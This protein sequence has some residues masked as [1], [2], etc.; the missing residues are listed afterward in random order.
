VL[1]KLIYGFFVTLCLFSPLSYGQN[2]SYEGKKSVT[3]GKDYQLLLSLKEQ[4]PL[5]YAQRYAGI[6]DALQESLS[7]YRSSKNLLRKEKEILE[8]ALDNF[9]K[10][11]FNWRTSVERKLAF[12]LYGPDKRAF[13]TRLLAEFKKHYAPLKKREEQLRIFHSILSGVKVPTFEGL[14]FEE[15]FLKPKYAQEYRQRKIA[16]YETLLKEAMDLPPK[17]PDKKELTLLYRKKID[18][19]R[20]R[21]LPTHKG[22]L[23]VLPMD[24]L[25]GITAL[26]SMGYT[27]KGA[28]IGVIEPVSHKENITG[29]HKDLQKNLL[30]KDTTLS[31]HGSHVTGIAAGKAQTVKDRL[32]TAP[33]AKVIFKPMR[34]SAQGTLIYF[35]KAHTQ[36]TKKVLHSTPSFESDQELAGLIKDLTQRGIRLINASFVFSL[37]PH[38]LNAF[39]HFVEKGG[40]LIKA[41]G[42]AGVPLGKEI[43]IDQK[44]LSKVQQTQTGIDSGF[45]HALRTF[46]ELLKG[47][48][49]VGNLKDATTLDKTSNQA[50]D[51]KERFLSAWGTQVSSTTTPFNR[52]PL[53]GTSMAAPMVTGSMALLMEAFPTCDAPLLAQGLLDSAAP[54]P[55]GEKTGQGR[56]DLISAFTLLKGVCGPPTIK[57]P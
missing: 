6:Q 10:H 36:G 17:H 29:I 46:P 55:Y 31:I 15:R 49:I 12:G 20:Y 27:G 25:M 28:V 1:Y 48:I 2:T 39:K 37:G 45:Y 44:K 34:A 53:T 47:V 40:V 30:N 11:L 19:W 41:A 5:V 13:Y 3:P 7:K 57:S 54:L 18:A 16:F 21:P 50:G 14:S 52:Q 24:E 32:G 22:T 26:R 9:E 33:K 4:Y 8:K 42:N 56:L 23:H 35:S 43:S 38:T 51:L